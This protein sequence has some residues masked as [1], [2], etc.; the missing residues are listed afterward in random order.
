M[1]SPSAERQWLISTARPET[2]SVHSSARTSRFKA[3]N[4]LRQ[5]WAS[6]PAKL[7]TIQAGADDI[8]FSSCLL[9]EITKDGFH[10]PF[11]THSCVGKNGQVTPTV[12]TALQ[13]L[14]D[15]L[16]S[17]IQSTSSQAK[18]VA[19]LNY[20]QIIPSPSDF[21][22]Q[23]VFPDKNVDPVCWGLSH[24]EKGAHDDAVIIQ[25]ALN[26]TIKSAVQDAQNAGVKNVFLIDISNLENHHEMCTG[27]PAVFSGEQMSKFNFDVTA[28]R[29]DIQAHAWRAGHPNSFGQTDIARAVEAQLPQPLP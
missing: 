15:A 4:F 18:T 7:V 14:H 19:V 13:H 9:Y 24:N 10:I 26:G 28:T 25:N 2:I 12:A 1:T 29:T 27:K 11:F 20:Y 21:D 23:S 17:T 8:N 6:S 16:L 22:H 3:T 5:A